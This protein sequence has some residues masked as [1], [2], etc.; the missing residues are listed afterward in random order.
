MPRAIE[1]V[2]LSGVCSKAQQRRGATLLQAYDRYKRRAFERSGR[3]WAHG[4][5]ETRIVELSV[6][7][8]NASAMT[9]AT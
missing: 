7:C 1:A 4:F 8:N 3:M 6:S 2:E 9:L 5:I